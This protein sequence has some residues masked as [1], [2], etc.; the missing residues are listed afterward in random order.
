[1]KIKLPNLFRLWSLEKESQRKQPQMQNKQKRQAD[2]KFFMQSLMTDQTHSQIH[3][4]SPAQSCNPEQS[5]FRYAELTFFLCSCLIIA[6][7]KQS[8]AGKKQKPNQ[9]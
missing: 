1:M 2:H 7:Q 5:L 8:D 6:G 3:N 9:R 4:K